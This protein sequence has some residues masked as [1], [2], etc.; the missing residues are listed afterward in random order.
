MSSGLAT[1]RLLCAS[2]R[3]ASNVL[4]MAVRADCLTCVSPQISHER[5][6]AIGRNGERSSQLNTCLAANEVYLLDTAQARAI[7]DAQDEVIRTQ[8][9]DVTMPS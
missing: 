7:I 9:R 1:S 8:W 6:M 2:E 4:N 5:R 3:N